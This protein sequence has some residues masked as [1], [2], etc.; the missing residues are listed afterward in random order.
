MNSPC[1]LV[2][3]PRTRM[4]PYLHCRRG[5]NI[6]R[7]GSRPDFSR[8]SEDFTAF[9][10]LKRQKS[11]RTA[12]L[13]LLMQSPNT[14]NPKRGSCSFHNPDGSICPLKVMNVEVAAPVSH[15]R[16]R[17]IDMPALHVD[18]SGLTAQELS[19]VRK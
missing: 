18:R 7:F 16:Q 4:A 15:E 17:L 5:A 6:P 19:I 13:T 8:P 10:Q 11:N 3:T 12:W 9:F 2:R 14:G 1:R